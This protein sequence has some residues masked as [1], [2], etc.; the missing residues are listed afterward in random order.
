M[1]DDRPVLDTLAAMTAGAP[2]AARAA[3]SLEECD[4]AP[5]ELM[6]ARMPPNIT[7]RGYHGRP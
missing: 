1:S 3:A 5:R 4:L 7:R 6:L 2:T